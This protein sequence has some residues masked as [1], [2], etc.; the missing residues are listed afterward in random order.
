MT[1]APGARVRTL[2]Q[3]T[4]GHTRL[5]GYLQ[6]ASGIVVARLGAFPLPDENALGRATAAL[7]DLYTVAFAARDVFEDARAGDTIYADL[8]AAYLEASP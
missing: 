4:G 3:R 5:P 6:H 1:L 8:F 7:D 2:A